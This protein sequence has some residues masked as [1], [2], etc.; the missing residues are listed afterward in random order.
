MLFNFIRGAGVNGLRGIPQWRK[1]ADIIRPLLFA[2]RKEIIYYADSFKIAFRED[3]SNSKTDYT[4]NFLRHDIIARIQEHINPNFI[5]T[6]QRTSEIFDQLEQYLQKETDDIL[7]SLIVSRSATEVVLDMNLLQTHPVFLQEHLLLHT[8]REFTGSE[9]EFNVVRA[10]F[11]LSH[12]TTGSLCAISGNS[13]M[14]RDREHLIFRRVSPVMRYRHRIELNR[15]YDFEQFHF[16]SL[17]VEQAAFVNNT[18]IAFVDGA[19]LGNELTLRTWNNG[20]AFVPLGM[21]QKKKLSDF[22]ID[23]KIPLFEKTDDP[24]AYLGR[25]Y[26][27]GLRQTSG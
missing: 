1:D 3:A 15:Q 7:P 16:R 21:R 25:Q 27:L 23:E 20:D 5:A 14:C 4:R 18:N 19:S 6:L 22:F 17:D 11:N 26:R 12:S 8:A 24:P 10:M 13:V 9:I 2:E